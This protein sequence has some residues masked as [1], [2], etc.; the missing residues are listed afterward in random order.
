MKKRR[1]QKNPERLNDVIAYRVTA[2][3]RAF[4]EKV[5]EEKNIGLGAAVRL[6]I[7]EVRMKAGAA[8]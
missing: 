5:A 3:Q 8:V 2:S 4:L 7:D 6:V 1:N